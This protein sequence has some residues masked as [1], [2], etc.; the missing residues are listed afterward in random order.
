VPYEA[1]FNFRGF[2]KISG[3]LILTLLVIL[4]RPLICLS[5]LAPGEE[6]VEHARALE[7]GAKVTSG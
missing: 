7:H 1:P 5:S 4:D 6:E 2:Q 3:L